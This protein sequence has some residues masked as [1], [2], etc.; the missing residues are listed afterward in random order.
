MEIE[1]PTLEYYG[2]D[3]EII[4]K[5]DGNTYKFEVVDDFQYG[6]Y[7]TVYIKM[8]YAHDWW[9][10]NAEEYCLELNDD[11]LVGWD[12]LQWVRAFCDPD[13]MIKEKMIKETESRALMQ[14]MSWQD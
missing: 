6:P 4:Y 2:D 10:I 1:T 13:E 11:W 12:N 3:E 7:R 9:L 14:I 8:R 5:R